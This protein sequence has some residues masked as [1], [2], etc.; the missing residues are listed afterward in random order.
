MAEFL[1]GGDMKNLYGVTQIELLLERVRNAKTPE[2]QVIMTEQDVLELKRVY[3]NQTLA[4]EVLEYYG[5]LLK[6]TNITAARKMI[7]ADLGEKAR[8][9][10]KKIVTSKWE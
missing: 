9:A 4:R 6:P 5:N 10:L 8:E 7:F 1:D 3:E 2:Q